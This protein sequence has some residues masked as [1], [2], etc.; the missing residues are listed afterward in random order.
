[1]S[2][3]SDFGL[4]LNCHKLSLLSKFEG[5]RYAFLTLAGSRKKE[6]KKKLDFVYK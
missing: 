4:V 2:F 3:F 1:M 6:K 5:M